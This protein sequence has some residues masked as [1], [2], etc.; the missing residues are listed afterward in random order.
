MSLKKQK[1]K[2]GMMVSKNPDTLQD[3]RKRK[4]VGKVVATAG[5]VTS[6][7]GNWKKPILSSVVLPAHAL[8]SCDGDAAQD[9]SSQ[10][11]DG[12]SDG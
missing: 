6:M 11:C 12:V 7:S 10:G 3:S 4:T 5:L 8:T 9:G 1:D 2:A